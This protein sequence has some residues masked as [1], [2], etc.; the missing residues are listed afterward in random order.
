M[1]PAWATRDSGPERESGV[2]KDCTVVKILAALAE[3]WSP[4]P[5][6]YITWLSIPCTSSSRASGTLFWPSRAPEHTPPERHI[7]TKTPMSDPQ[8]QYTWRS[9]LL[10]KCRPLVVE[11]AGIK[12]KSHHSRLGLQGKVSGVQLWSVS[13]GLESGKGDR[14]EP[15]TFQVSKEVGR[16]TFSTFT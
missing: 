5:S 4:D 6:I 11:I 8:V 2:L 14:K 15:W 13:G 10:R 7:H 1:R 16:I 9:G 3:D 12:N